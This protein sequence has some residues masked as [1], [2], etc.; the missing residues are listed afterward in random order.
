MFN[1]QDATWLYQGYVNG[2]EPHEDEHLNEVA[3]ELFSVPIY[4]TFILTCFFF[5][6]HR[7]DEVM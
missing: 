3:S 2:N 4:G 7:K 5:L 1:V 6:V